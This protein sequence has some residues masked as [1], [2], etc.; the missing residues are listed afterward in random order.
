MP[1]DQFDVEVEK[2]RTKQK[3]VEASFWLGFWFFVIAGCTT[4]D[5]L[6]K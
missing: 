6:M 4:Y 5:V 3:I 2:Q 1:R